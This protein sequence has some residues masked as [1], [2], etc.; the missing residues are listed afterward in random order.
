MMQVHPKFAV[1][2]DNTVYMGSGLGASSCRM[3]WSVTNVSCSR[4]AT[5]QVGIVT[6]SLRRCRSGTV[7]PRQ[8]EGRRCGTGCSTPRLV[9][10]SKASAGVPGRAALSFM[11]DTMSD[12][13]LRRV[14]DPSPTLHNRFVPGSG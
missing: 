8:L 10:I 1:S 7:W 4:G 13:G 2:Q 11:A 6:C 14:T 3:C 12:L 9:K 5:E